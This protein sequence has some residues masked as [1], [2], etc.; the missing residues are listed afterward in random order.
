MVLFPDG[1]A[2]ADGCL[3]CQSFEEPG[4][5]GCVLKAQGITDLFHGEVRMEEGSFCFKHD[6]LV[7]KDS[8]CSSRMLPYNVIQ[9]A[10]GDVQQSGVIGHLVEGV[11]FFVNE[12]FETTKEGRFGEGGAGVELLL[13]QTGQIQEEDLQVALEDTFLPMLRLPVFGDHLVHQG[14][15]IFLVGGCQWQGLSIAG[16]LQD[17]QLF[18]G[19]LSLCEKEFFGKSEERAADGS[20]AFFKV[21]LVRQGEEQVTG[22]DLMADEVDPVK[23][24][25]F[26]DQE[27]KIIIFTVRQE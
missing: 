8:R 24:A 4:K 21:Y 26:P 9:M 6:A 16:I 25:A 27:E 20:M 18:Q 13:I 10:S 23:I 14:G 3:A 17:G 15:E 2:E 11:V 12:L 5:I 22:P 19:Q 1:V 7:D